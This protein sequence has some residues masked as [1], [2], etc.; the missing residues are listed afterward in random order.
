MRLAALL[1]ALLLPACFSA[2]IDRA[3]DRADQAVTL[4][5]E[6][7]RQIAQDTLRDADARM[8][9]LAADVAAK[10]DAARAAALVDADARVT[11]QRVA[12]AADAAKLLADVDTRLDRQRKETLDA[13]AA[14][15]DRNT[16]AVAAVVERQ[17]AAWIAESAAWRA[18]IR[19]VLSAVGGATNGGQKFPGSVPPGSSDEG[20]PLTNYLITGASSTLA[21]LIIRHLDHR[22]KAAREG[23]AAG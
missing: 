7:A 19:P 12:A 11:A 17:S 14:I 15:V 1:L 23:K 4:A 3:G 9:A 16:A 8:S 6:K 13:V 5:A 18:E 10:A 21:A 2:P 20:S 22:R